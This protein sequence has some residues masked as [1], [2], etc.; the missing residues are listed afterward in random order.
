MIQVLIISMNLVDFIKI[1]LLK[2]FA[3]YA[4]QK[5]RSGIF[6]RRYLNDIL[7]EC[8]RKGIHL[9][10]SFVPLLL[11]FAH[12]LTIVLLFLALILYLIS[13]VL[14]FKGF[15]IPVIS[16]ITNIAARKRDEN[17]IVWGPVTLVIGILISSIFFDLKPATVGILALAFGDG[18]ASLMGKLFGKTQIPFT[19]GKTVVGSLSCF[20]AVFVSSSLVLTNV[21]M[22]LILGFIAMIIEMLPL[23]DFDNICIPVVL[24]S[25]V[26]FAPHIKNI[27]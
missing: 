18:T 5:N 14:R 8:F 10:S 15:N 9:C 6:V 24:A 21:A 23:K 26:Q 25:I 19:G 12:D 22:G 20:F 7:K 13:E 1:S 27:F 16:V 2:N 11:A 17:H 4:P 3:Y